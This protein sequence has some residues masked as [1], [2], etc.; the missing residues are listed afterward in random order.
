[1]LAYAAMDILLA[2]LASLSIGVGAVMQQSTA[3]RAK[4]FNGLSIFLIKELLS[5]PIW[6]LGVFTM[7]LGY[8][9]QI[10]AIATG[11]LIVVE[12]I[13]ASSIAFALVIGALVGSTKL[14][15][16]DYVAIA[17]SIIGLSG[18]LVATRAKSGVYVSSFLQ[19]L[20]ILV[21]IVIGL[22]VL[23]RASVKIIKWNGVSL[24]LASGISYGTSDALTKV[25]IYALSHSRLPFFSLWSLYGLVIFGILGFLF[26]QSS[27]NVANLKGSFSA[28]AIVEPFVGSVL[29]SVVLREQVLYG[30]ADG[31]VVIGLVAL[32]FSGLIALIR[33]SAFDMLTAGRAN[34]LD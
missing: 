32:M 5:R 21:V 2:F 27:Y 26:Q 22:L 16:K 10:G 6:L 3:S 7:I 8:A 4:T 11:D 18:F 33:S 9:F 17:C 20:P 23:N 19:W 12:P 31:I 28:I 34:T 25:T 14:R 13:L 15:G 30:F 1:L 24:A 29:A